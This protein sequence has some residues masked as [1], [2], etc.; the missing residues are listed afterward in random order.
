MFGAI[1]SY[2]TLR[3]YE[4][5]IRTL[6]RYGFGEL[7]GRLNLLAELKLKRRPSESPANGHQTRAVRF[8]LM[9][10][11]L[12]PTFIKIGQIL[13]TRPDLLPPDI[14]A[15][16]ASLRDN[17]TPTVWEKMKPRLE[18]DLGCPADEVF[19]EFDTTPLASASLAQVYRAR[20]ADG[21]R[22]AVKIIRPSVARIIRDDLVIV[23][24][25]ATLAQS[26]LS[27]I[28]HWNIDEIVKQLRG[29][30][31][32]ELDMQHEGRNADIFRANFVGD[33]TVYV[34]E[35]C[36]EYTSRNVLV[37]ELIEGRP[38]AELFGDGADETT[39]KD[40]AIKGAK[41]V[42]KQIFVHGFFQAD[43]HPGNAFV[44][45]DNV[46]CFLD[47]GMFGRLDDMSLD[48]LS[49][50]LDAMVNRDVARLIR[51]ARDAELLPLDA[52]T[53]PL[54]LAVTDMLEQYHGI[55]LKRLSVRQLLADIA[56]LIGRHRLKVRPDFLFML[57]AMSTIEA[58]G[59]GLDPDF[60]MLAQLRP[61]VRSLMV[62]RFAP[63][64][65][66]KQAL[67]FG[68]DVTQLTKEAPEHMLELLRRARAGRFRLEMHHVGLDKPLMRMDRTA[69]KLTLGMIVGAS[70]IA[71]A[72]MMDVGLGPS[73]LGIP[74]IGGI[75][76]VV[77]GIVGLWIVFDIFRTYRGG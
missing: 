72:I 39:R 10:E 71:S 17:V 14:V 8:R 3:R 59:R 19:P 45:P 2:R 44:L 61:F 64:H 30:I 49:R 63:D 62:R 38:I 7:V 34:P 52:E 47:F 22:V 29:S 11:Q 20:L 9:V 73:V 18:A 21:R 26:R 24:H 23:E 28:Q 33:Q 68:E 74:V 5:I 51:V 67:R 46:I 1:R 25:L 76:F 32:H 54:R 42:L 13:S 57:K 37:M 48:T 12:G 15:E 66:L 75:G 53:Q 41:A 40:L 6:S 58:T 27:E 35:I 4:Q 16:L 69:D 50:A 70:I 43:P 56:D 36:W 31:A 60:D 55:P 65:M 77:A